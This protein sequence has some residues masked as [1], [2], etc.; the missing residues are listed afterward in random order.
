MRILG[1]ILLKARVPK[2]GDPGQI[3]LFGSRTVEVKG[4]LAKDP[5]GRGVHFVREHPAHVHA[6]P[7]H[8]AGADPTPQP[9]HTR[10]A[11]ARVDPGQYR[12]VGFYDLREFDWA[13][14]KRL[15]GREED[16]AQCERCD[17]KHWRVFRVRGP[18]DLFEV[19]ET[20]ARR[21][22]A[23]IDPTGEQFRRL[24][25]EF[26]QAVKEH[27]DAAQAEAAEQRSIHVR[28]HALD[29][30]RH[31]ASLPVPAFQDLGKVELPSVTGG[32]RFV[33]RYRL[34]DDNAKGWSGQR[35]DRLDDGWDQQERDRALLHWRWEQVSARVPSGTPLRAEIID[36]AKQWASAPHGLDG[37]AEI[38]ARRKA[39]LAERMAK[40][41]PSLGGLGH[42][43][44]PPP[45]PAPRPEK[46]APAPAPEPAVPPTGK[47]RYRDPET[48]GHRIGHVTGGGPKG[49]TVVDEA[50]GTER[51]VPHGHY[52]VHGE[53][54]E[55]EEQSPARPAAPAKDWR[56]EYPGLNAYPPPG[57]KVQV[58]EGAGPRLTWTTADGKTGRAFETSALKAHGERRFGQLQDTGRKLSGL[59]DAQD[60]HLKLGG[61]SAPVVLAAASALVDRGGLAADR[62][63][64]LRKRDAVVSRGRVKV[65]DAELAEPRVAAVV[66]HLQT[67]PGDRLFQVEDHRGEVRP[68]TVQDLDAYTQDHGDGTTVEDLH[69]FHG[70]RKW[71]EA[72]DRAGP[73]D[74]PKQAEGRIRRAGKE[75]AA[76]TGH[77]D[78]HRV[79]NRHVSPKVVEAYRQGLTMS[80]RMAKGGDG[81]RGPVYHRLTVD[82]RRFLGHLDQVDR[83]DP[84]GVKKV[85]ADAE[86]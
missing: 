36:L 81:E 11:P 85:P 37:Q 72:V 50:T 34:G 14:G 56:K 22:F 47:V 1:R 75:V 68:I 21:M 73:A 16:A 25:R 59:R 17:K 58:H 54:P 10:P 18:E 77:G 70:T 19:G 69:H 13:S 33:R 28:E 42:Q 63:V 46:P 62:V 3:G 15:P 64:A 49:V 31:V 86:D 38:T 82:E 23:G 5:G 53:A 52:V 6:T 60:E 65:G 61:A 2:E 80:G 20:C 24:D 41:R 55:P 67:L 12:V 30:A 29:V 45:R 40:A 84:Y 8:A 35:L 43:A 4:H 76:A 83:A 7:A 51:Q 71:T 57:A 32:S 78:L 26:K 79:L 74:D 39:K 48:G 9:F 66:A 27:E 44:A